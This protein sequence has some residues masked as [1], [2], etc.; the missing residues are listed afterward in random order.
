MG[1]PADH[2]DRL[3]SHEFLLYF[4]SLHEASLDD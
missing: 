1:I 4:L 3:V 2:G